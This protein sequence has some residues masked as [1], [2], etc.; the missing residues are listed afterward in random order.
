MLGG[1]SDACRAL[2]AVLRRWGVSAEMYAWNFLF[3]MS[4]GSPGAGDDKAENSLGVGFSKEPKDWA[5]EALQKP[6]GLE[7]PNHFA[8]LKILL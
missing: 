7:A 2:E 4:R 6:V 5:P 8:L 3:F 1:L